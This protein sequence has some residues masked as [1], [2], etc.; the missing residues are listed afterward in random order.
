MNVIVAEK[1]EMCPVLS[2]MTI[3]FCQFPVS[4]MIH[5]RRESALIPI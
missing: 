5:R 2:V 4:A 1:R 3:N